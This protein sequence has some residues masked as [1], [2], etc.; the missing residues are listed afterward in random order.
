MPAMAWAPTRL[1][2]AL[3]AAGA[4]GLSLAALAA[5]A[6][7]PKGFES[8]VRPFVA[9]HCA[10]CHGAGRPK[11]KLDLTRFATAAAAKAEPGVWLEVAA[12]LTTGEMPPEGRE[13]PPAAAAAAVIDWIGRNV[14]YQG[15]IDPGRPVLRRL[16]RTEYRNTVRDLL[17]IEFAADQE[18][19]ADAV[20]HGFD[21]QGDAL[22]LNDLQ[23]EKYVQAAEWIAER[24]VVVPD[25]GPPQAYR[26]R[27]DEL[28]GPRR[29]EQIALDSPG[30]AHAV[31][32][33]PRAGEYLLRVHTHGDQAGPE[34]CQV[35]LQLD[36]IALHVAPVTATAAAPEVVQFRARVEAGEHR[37]GARFRNDYYEP[38]AAD[39]ALRG[40]R[41]L[42]VSWIEVVGPLDPPPRSAFQRALFERFGAE[43]GP[44]RLRA[45]L[46]H[47]AERA[48][49]RPAE[50]SELARLEQL[51]ADGPLELRLQTAL[52]ALL[53]SPHFLYRVEA[54]PP[55]SPPIRD[56]NGHELATRLSYFLW[57]SMPDEEL[58]AAAADG[59]LLRPQVLDEQTARLLRS[60]RARALADDFAAQWLQLRSLG[61]AAPD[62]QQFPG[63]DAAL[64][65]D[66]RAETLALFE[67]VLR[68]ER[69]AWDLLEADFS[70]LNER[71]AQWYGI[72]GVH[73][74]D[75]RRVA[76]DDAPRRG[77][78]THASV[79][80]LTSNP[81]RTSPVKRG[82]WILDNL[83]GAPPPPPP[84]GVAALDERPPA[85]ADDRLRARLE[86]HRTDA[87]C[88]VCHVKMDALGFG[89]EQYDAVGRYRERDGSFAVD[90]S[91][92]L[93]DG[94][95]FDGAL[96]LIQV[97][98]ADAAFLRC[99]T[100]KLLIYALGRG[101]EP[102]DRAVVDRILAALD[103]Q[104]PT[105][106]AILRGI[107]HSP[108]FRQRRTGGA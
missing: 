70:Y 52:A 83:L 106:T 90:A 95:R 56:L 89:L 24:A 88:A 62:P 74:P 60:P 45:M 71:L 63:Y 68:E 35:A 98:R 17:G 66:M 10:D 80:T 33:F 64:G 54:D 107:V 23:L 39:P 28:A 77:L 85:G 13:R 53:A 22:S 69:S 84:P 102:A 57:S 79:L 15:P 11:A 42:Y 46:V 82:K 96:E 44:R 76:L 108:A 1:R 78:L 103:P 25:P 29:G 3:L 7:E 37:V 104:R 55:G 32:R 43:L 8:L 2:P 86:R 65:A 38:E 20:G 100:E 92:Q 91:G 36:G 67:A 73:G 81:A 9:Q 27:A 14:S 19:P 50:K 93:P 75:W 30:E 99:L 94:R 34:P 16:N 59:S 21:N 49:R 87:D 18:F 97:L 105:L 72:R 4:G 12:R 31:H 41:N 40:D 26:Y 5:P 101:L 51:A 61:Q 48:W 47:L 6:Q 58:L